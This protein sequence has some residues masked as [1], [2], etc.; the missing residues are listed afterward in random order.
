MS[1]RSHRLQGHTF[2]LDDFYDWTPP[3]VTN[4]VMLAGSAM[5]V[6]PFD[7][8]VCAFILV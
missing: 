1:L 7:A 5:E 6:T 3:G 2:A 8:W 4:F